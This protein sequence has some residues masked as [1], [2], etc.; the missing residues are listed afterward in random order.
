M[1]SLIYENGY[2]WIEIPDE[3][4]AEAEFLEYIEGI[5]YYVRNTY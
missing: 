4:W 2:W 1:Y 5:P 3:V